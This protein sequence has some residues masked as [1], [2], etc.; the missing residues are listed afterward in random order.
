MDRREKSLT[1]A[2]METSAWVTDERARAY[3][4]GMQLGMR[5]TMKEGD[6][7]GHPRKI[8]RPG[9]GYEADH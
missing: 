3:E 1:L 9:E 7:L 2:A 4:E 6:A 8:P 5:V